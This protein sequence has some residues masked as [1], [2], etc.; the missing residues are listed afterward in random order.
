[1]PKPENGNLSAWVTAG[2]GLL[3]DDGADSLSSPPAMAS[4][5][6]S[7]LVKFLPTFCKVASKGLALRGTPEQRTGRNHRKIQLIGQSSFSTRT[8]GT[9]PT[10]IA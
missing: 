10:G 5:N 4:K 3:D 1:V 8:N 6:R 2:S 7:L 9:K